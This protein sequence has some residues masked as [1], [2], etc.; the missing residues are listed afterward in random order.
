MATGVQTTYLLP[1]G[2][3]VTLPTTPTT[4]A[5]QVAAPAASPVAG[6]AVTATELANDMTAGVAWLASRPFFSGYQTSAESIPASTWT[7]VSLDTEQIDNYFGHSD[8]ANPSRWY[9]PQSANIQAG[10]HDYYL[11]TGSVKWASTLTSANA[12]IAGTRLT[13]GTVIEGCKLA[14]ASGHNIATWTADIME[15][16]ASTDYIEL[17][18]FQNTAGALST[19][20]GAGALPWLQCRWVGTNRLGTFALPAAPHV[21]ASN[22]QVSA[23]ATG[24][25]PQ[26][27]VKVPLNT[28]L[29]AYLNFQYGPPLARLTSQSTAQSIASS[30]TAWT[31]IQFP[32]KS[33]DNYSGWSSGANTKYTVQRAGLYTFIG[34]AALDGLA[35]QTGY[36]ACRLSINGGARFVPGMAAAA[37]TSNIG[38]RVVAKCTD[39][40]NAGDTIEL[41]IQQNSGS[42]ITISNGAG[43]GSRLLALWEA[44]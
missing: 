21:W 31:S 17:T 1:S 10:F 34:F 33:I 9:P 43:N 41:Q 12:G 24:A 26:G 44:L 2:Q 23:A 3:Q 35:S 8:S 4:W 19:S 39:R 22:D 38:N 36:V 13:G 42:S 28:E 15:V 29:A 14:G 40:F 5:D 20:N 18:A 32:T 7:A 27:G 37:T 25:S 11:A 6:T 30:T 16:T